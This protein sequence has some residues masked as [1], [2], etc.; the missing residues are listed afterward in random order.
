MENEFKRNH[1]FMAPA[2]DYYSILQKFIPSAVMS[3]DVAAGADN[4]PALINHSNAG[5]GGLFS[6]SFAPS[7]AFLSNFDKDGNDLSN[8]NKITTDR[9]PLI[10][11]SGEGNILPFNQ[12]IPGMAVSEDSGTSSANPLELLLQGTGMPE[13]FMNN[14]D[15][16]IPDM[17]NFLSG[18]ASSSAAED[19]N[20]AFS[21]FLPQGIQDTSVSADSG[22]N[23]LSPDFMNVP[24]QLSHFSLA[25]GLK[26]GKNQQAIPE[27]AN[28]FGPIGNKSMALPSG[29]SF[30]GQNLYD[31]NRELNKKQKNSIV[32][33][34][35]ANNAQV[36]FKNSFSG[37]NANPDNLS[38]VEK[39]FHFSGGMDNTDQGKRNI[40]PVSDGESGMSMNMMG[41]P[42]NAVNGIGSHG[43]G[44]QRN[45]SVGVGDISVAHDYNADDLESMVHEAMNNLS[46]DVFR[47]EAGIS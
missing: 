23:S 37:K 13:S 12:V 35:V 2:A 14:T 45:V 43:S 28:N 47:S 31:G 25:N 9:L 20:N 36:F 8:I 46:G 30:P 3:M 4:T 22:K 44:V 17:G 39:L 27:F 38:P 32:P 33:D 42:L 34:Y 5:S 10:S 16:A 29:M 24:D 40:F 11:N 6:P 19:S 7:S 15:I 18:G 1:K 21:T 26:G 41:K